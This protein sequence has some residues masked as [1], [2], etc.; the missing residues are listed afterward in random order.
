MSYFV[1]LILW[2]KFVNVY[3]EHIQYY[4][5]LYSVIMG[6][7]KVNNWKP[8]QKLYTHPSKAIQS[9]NIIF[10]IYEQLLLDVRLVYIILR[11]IYNSNEYWNIN[12]QTSSV[13][14]R[15]NQYCLP[16]NYGVILISEDVIVNGACWPYVVYS[17]HCV[18]YTMQ[19]I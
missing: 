1:Y 2:I 8:H 6:G 9:T 10:N 17:V 16:I 11:G 5:A 7:G 15:S 14:S 19:Y 18:L 4:F 3:Y 12:I 13:S